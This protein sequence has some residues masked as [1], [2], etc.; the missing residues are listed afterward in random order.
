MAPR[1]AAP[2]L[3]AHFLARSPSMPTPITRLE[4]DALPSFSDALTPP[5]AHLFAQGD[6][7][8]LGQPALAIVGS[9]RASIQGM[10]D[11]RW[12]AKALAEA[13]FVVVSGLALGIDGAAHEGALAAGGGR[14]IAV[15]AHG[16]DTIYPSAHQRLAQDILDAGGLLLS[17]YEGGVPPRPF[18]F[19]HRNRIIAA[20]SQAVC[21]LEAAE[22]SGSISTALSA[23]EQG[24]D[25]FV[26]PGSIHSGLHAGGHRLIRQGAGL[27]QSPQELMQDLGC[28]LSSALQRPRAATDP[29]G[30]GTTAQG[31]SAQSAFPGLEDQRARTVFAQL[32]FEPVDAQSL[33][34]MNASSLGDTLAGLLMCELAGLATRH[35]DGSWSRLR[36]D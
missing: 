18:Q 27:V 35:P 22:G 1:Q 12:F 34:N 31:G 13:G 8:L 9:R 19:L 4:R 14:T 30:L 16:L 20:L 24:S 29:L 28:A 10:S 23:L 17:E 7:E 25:V 33:A 5:I 3:G 6:A 36:R 2:S 21:L 15:L 26:V 11:A 32:R